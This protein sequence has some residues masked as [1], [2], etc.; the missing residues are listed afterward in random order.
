[1]KMGSS[2]AAGSKLAISAALPATED[3]AGYAALTYTAIGGIEKLGP[4]GPVAAKVEF[5]PLDGP[6]EKHKGSVD[7]GSINPPIAIDEA[8][9][10]Q[11]LLRTAAAPGNNALYS[12]KVTYPSG[13]VRYSQGRVFGFPETVDGAD[14]VLMA[15]PTIEFS[16][17]LIQVPPT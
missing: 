4:I 7:Y 16:K 10:G 5:Q 11:T 12:F 1:M 9:A 14:T 17:K 6:K 3:A 8:D 15:N 13:S 2:T